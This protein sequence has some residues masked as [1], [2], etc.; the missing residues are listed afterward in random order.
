MSLKPKKHS[1]IKKMKEKMAAKPSKM[2]TK[3]ELPPYIMIVS[4]GVKTEP[5][6]LEGFVNKINE[7]LGV[8]AA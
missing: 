3:N 4:E 8:T 7:K 5:L 2:D 1:D 6:Y